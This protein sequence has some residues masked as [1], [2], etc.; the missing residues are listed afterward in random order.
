MPN[1][2]YPTN[3]AEW[4]AFLAALVPLII[5]ASAGMWRVWTERRARTEGDWRRLHE[6]ALILYNN[7]TQSG[8]W[9][10]I[11]AAREL[12][13]LKSRRRD[14]QDIAALAALW[15]KHHPQQTD[16]TPIIVAELEAFSPPN[17]KN[18][19][20]WLLETRRKVLERI[21]NRSA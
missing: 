18:Q 8:L 20:A 14:A 19:P 13:R 17:R 10:Q 11:A 15:F 16:G 4:A 12:Q 5:W 1:S 7:A 9:G 2:I 21:A 3:P 6:L